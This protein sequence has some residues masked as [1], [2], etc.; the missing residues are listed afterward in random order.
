MFDIVHGSPDGRPS[1]QKNGNA[2]VHSCIGIVFLCQFCQNYLEVLDTN[3]TEQISGEVC[4]AVGEN[5]RNFLYK[6]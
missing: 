5:S 1:Y 2:G 4:V 3:A 6:F